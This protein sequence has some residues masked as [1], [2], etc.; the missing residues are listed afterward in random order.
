[1]PGAGQG[2]RLVAN[3]GAD[4]S[5]PLWR[6]A[7]ARWSDG[8]LVHMHG[9]ADEA[10][11]SAGLTVAPGSATALAATQDALV[12]MAYPFSQCAA[13]VDV[14]PAACRANCLRREQALSCCGFDEAQLPKIRR[15]RMPAV[16][17][18]DL[19]GAR[20]QLG[21]PTLGCNALDAG[22]G[23]CMAEQVDPARG[24]VGGVF[25]GGVG[26]GGRGGFVGGGGRGGGGG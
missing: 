6:A 22:V 24:G 9:A 19:A 25:A 11:R 13:A 4:Q 20:V 17:A 8:L 3:V 5:N 1:M 2:V 10:D 15:G 21:S 12:N 7:R 18:T 26:G 16:N 14:A 23:R